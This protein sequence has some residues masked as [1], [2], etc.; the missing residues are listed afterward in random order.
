MLHCY[1]IRIKKYLNLNFYT[2]IYAL[3]SYKSPKI[4]YIPIQSVMFFTY[5]KIFIKNQSTI[6]RV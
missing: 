5:E 4:N 2:K 1:F 3:I 6:D